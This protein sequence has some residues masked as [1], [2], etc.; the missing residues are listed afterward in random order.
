[1]PVTSTGFDTIKHLTLYVKRLK[2]K[3]LYCYY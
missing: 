3:V 2:M 1:V